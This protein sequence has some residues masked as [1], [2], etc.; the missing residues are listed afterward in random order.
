MNQILAFAR[1]KPALPFTDAEAAAFERDIAES[2]KPMSLLDRS[3]NVVET[4]LSKLGDEEIRLEHEIAE[5][6]ERLRQVRVAAKAYEA[7]KTILVDGAQ[8][9]AAE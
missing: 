8:P 4:A 6:T 1:R 5:R 3:A 9:A 7:A 2:I